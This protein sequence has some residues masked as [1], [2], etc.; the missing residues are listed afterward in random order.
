MVESKWALC[1]ITAFFMSCCAWLL[2]FFS[3]DLQRSRPRR[4]DPEAMERMEDKFEQLLVDQGLM[5]EL[6][7]EKRSLPVDGAA[8]AATENSDLGH[9][10][11]S[12]QSPSKAVSPGTANIGSTDSFSTMRDV[13]LG[14]GGKSPEGSPLSPQR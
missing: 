2:V 7:D 4:N 6:E 9:H 8:A 12:L 11:A 13:A 3:L 5:Q 1:C 14:S 10:Y